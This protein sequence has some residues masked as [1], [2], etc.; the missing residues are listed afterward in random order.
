MGQIYFMRGGCGLV[1]IE[2]RIPANPQD[3]KVF[4]ENNS[5]EKEKILIFTKNKKKWKIKKFIIFLIIKYIFLLI[6]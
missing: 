4:F 5:F 2:L 3:K 6:F 1:E